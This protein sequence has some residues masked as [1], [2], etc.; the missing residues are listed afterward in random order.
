MSRR[1]VVALTPYYLPAYRGGGPIRTL[2]AMVAL[3]TQ[4]PGGTPTQFRIV[5]S[6]H[7][8]GESDPLPV[9]TDRWVPVGGAQVRYVRAGSARSWLRAFCDVRAHAPDV[10]YLNGVFPWW[11]SIVPAALHRLGL[12]RARALLVAPRGEFGV[13][14]LAL[15]APKKRAFL[16][17]ARATGL[18]R[19]ALWHASTPLEADEIRAIFPGVQVLVRE[20]ESDLPPTASRALPAEPGRELRLVF[21]SRISPKK[22]LHV[23][24]AAL[25]DVTTA[26]SLDVYGDAAEP[27]YLFR[28]EQLADRA[29]AAGHLV[30]F[31]GALPHEQVREALAAHDAF[32]LPTSSENFGH[33]VAE[34]LSTGCP[35]LVS[36]TTPWTD[37]VA[38]GAG[39]VVPDGD[40]A[41]VVQR[42]ADRSP[43]ELI[44]RRTL[45][46][47]GYDRW[48]AGRPQESVF[49]LLDGL[50]GVRDVR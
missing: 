46:A 33:V 44:A 1:T 2:A 35:V 8:W 39:E 36:D 32:A 12:L 41:R 3:H 26:V 25:P 43:G 21:L 29:A 14:A 37:V 17:L 38:A 15:K 6:D 7:D 27:E 47:D 45:A 20:N 5:T 11:T 42:W 30:T 34:A 9:D 19:G 24:L 50:N 40:W 48:I 10:L 18:Y 13:G 31:H 49:D 23:L 22:G 16:T 28:C 4:P